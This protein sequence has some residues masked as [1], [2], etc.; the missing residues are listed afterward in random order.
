M[1]EKNKFYEK[2]NEY[3]GIAKVEH[4]GEMFFSVFFNDDLVMNEV[5]SNYLGQAISKGKTAEEALIGSI[6]SMS[7]LL[8]KKRK[9]WEEM[10]DSHSE[11]CHIL[12]KMG[13]HIDRPQDKL[14]S[15]GLDLIREEK[16]DKAGYGVYDFLEKDNEHLPLTDPNQK[17]LT[18]IYVDVEDKPFLDVLPDLIKAV[19][20]FN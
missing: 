13:S 20:S 14:E 9:F 6:K 1:L 7:K 3:S 17:Y 12:R 5:F 15:C 4:E 16:G 2:F 18:K 8:G 10:Y 19:G 11:M